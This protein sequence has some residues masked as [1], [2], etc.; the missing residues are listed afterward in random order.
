MSTQRFPI[1]SRLA[2]AFALSIAGSASTVAM[3]HDDQALDLSCRFETAQQN[4]QEARTM[5]PISLAN[6]DY[7]RYVTE[8][9]AGNAALGQSELTCSVR[10]G[11]GTQDSRPEGVDP[12][13]GALDVAARS[14]LAM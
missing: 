3:P 6:A 7:S 1:I 14:T 11:H 4:G 5:P 8:Y 2:V 9:L 10:D 13:K 12:G